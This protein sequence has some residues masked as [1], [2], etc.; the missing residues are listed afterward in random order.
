LITNSIKHGFKPDEQ[1]RVDIDVAIEDELVKIKY[2]D[3]GKGFDN[4]TDF[5]ER[6]NFG[7]MVIQVLLTQLDADWDIESNGGMRFSMNFERTE[8]RGPSKLF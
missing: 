5:L 7:S 1:V 8:Y 3:Y 4:D 6:G 2:R